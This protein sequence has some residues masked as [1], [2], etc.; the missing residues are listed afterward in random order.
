MLQLL[1]AAFVVAGLVSCC[2]TPIVRR[3]APALG[4]ID[5]PGHR[6]VHV[7][8][9]PR[10]GGIAI[11]LGAVVPL[12]ATCMLC[13][14]DQKHRLPGTAELLDSVSDT[15]QL[16]WQ[17]GAIAVGAVVLFLA[18]LADDRWSLSWKPRLFL[19]CAVAFGVVA[20]GVRATVFVG[21]PWFGYAATVLWILVLT[22]AMNFLDNMD[23][24]SAGIGLIA[25]LLFAAILILMVRTPAISAA[26][27]LMVLAGSLTGF[28]IWN[29][30]PASI[31]MGDCG[32][33]LIGFM[34]ATLTVTG[35]FY[36]RSGS[37]HVML[38]P[39]CVMAVPLYDFCTVILIRL[40]HGRSPFHG[41][42]SH[43]SHRLVELG[44]KPAHA[45]LTIHL[46]TLMTGLG[47]LL[48]YKVADWSGATLVVALIICVLAVIAILET[49]GR[50]S[51]NVMQEALSEVKAQAANGAVIRD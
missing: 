42:K 7:T 19:Q 28:L 39:L 4:L 34:L 44:L 23:A 26:L 41:D 11:F 31:F 1:I 40:R 14:L 43:F 29:R 24:L 2:V 27:P 47:G 10:G 17:Y 48:L 46:T 16:G 13:L 32:S 37:R 9:T 3:F 21:Q 5:L 15:T 51:V 18:G 12:L 33:N 50:K 20:A 25:S 6:K 45:V 38:A 49:V 22:N 36:E 8:P 35:T 30:P